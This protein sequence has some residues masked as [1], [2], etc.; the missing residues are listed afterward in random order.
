M[1]VK[2][3]RPHI[4]AIYRS[5]SAWLPCC[6]FFI[7]LHLYFQLH[8]IHIT[9]LKYDSACCIWVPDLRVSNDFKI[10]A[11]W[12]I[13]LCSRRW[14]VVILSMHLAADLPASSSTDVVVFQIPR[15]LL[16]DQ[17]CSVQ[18]AELQGK[19]RKHQITDTVEQQSAA[20]LNE[21]VIFH[22]YIKHKC[23]HSCKLEA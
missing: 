15:S 8:Q 21:R 6:V 1:G 7:P 22:K 18:E 13:G 3:R 4:L 20:Y 10:C 2:V 14:I 11:L 12:L 16:I 5:W 23:K 9:P 19:Q 17:T